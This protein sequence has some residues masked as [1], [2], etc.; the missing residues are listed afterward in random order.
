MDEHCKRQI[1]NGSAK[2]KN[3]KIKNIMDNAYKHKVI[4]DYFATTKAQKRLGS[5]NEPIKKGIS[6]YVDTY[7]QISRLEEKLPRLKARFLPTEKLTEQDVSA[8]W[9]TTYLLTKTGQLCESYSIAVDANSGGFTSLPKKE[10]N[11]ILSQPKIE[12]LL[13]LKSQETWVESLNKKGKKYYGEAPYGLNEAQRKMLEDVYADQLDKLESDEYAKLFESLGKENNTR[14]SHENEAEQR[15]L[16]MDHEKTLLHEEAHFLSAANQILYNNN[17]LKIPMS[18]LNTEEAS[19]G[20]VVETY[21][22]VP[23]AEFILDKNGNFVLDSKGQTICNQYCDL[24]YYLHEGITEFITMK[25]VDKLNLEYNGKNLKYTDI[26]KETLLAYRMYEICV[27]MF[28]AINN[29][30]FEKSYFN[31]Q[32]IVL[33]NLNDKFNETFE[34]I[35]DN[36]EEL[37][38]CY[39]NFVQENT[40]KSKLQLFECFRETMFET[41][42]ML[43]EN[44]KDVKDIYIGKHINE[45]QLK[46]FLDAQNKFI[47]PFQWIRHVCYEDELEYDTERAFKGMVKEYL[48]DFKSSNRL[49]PEEN[50]KQMCKKTKKFLKENNQE[51]LQSVFP[52]KKAPIKKNDSASEY[53]NKVM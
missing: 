38:R 40:A 49:K 21:G 50:L 10:R 42:S 30:E 26:V 43:A 4:D 36:T 37:E 44:L 46:K 20:R 11:K 52:L 6:L 13:E 17:G 41:R 19:F 16:K 29:G 53:E 31:G 47:T 1:I 34:S 7:P 45:E 33:G 5:L 32:A 48:G 18:S 35:Y 28:D 15:L 51:Q 22:G 8:G 27:E 12:E 2:M 14:K 3:S 39:E 24:N 23:F 9:Q 25:M